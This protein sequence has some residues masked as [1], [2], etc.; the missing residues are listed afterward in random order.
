MPLLRTL[1]LLVSIAVLSITC[2]SVAAPPDVSESLSLQVLVEVRLD[3]AGAATPERI[4]AARAALQTALR[5]ADIPHEVV[6][7]YA[8]IPWVTL[9]IRPQDRAA[10]SGL[11]EASAIR[12][13]SIERIQEKAGS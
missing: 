4:A 2:R 3:G 10:V 7:T 1:L 5:K 6:R 8:T 9:R 12:D 11:P 13:D